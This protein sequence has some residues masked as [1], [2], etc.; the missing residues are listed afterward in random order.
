M[1]HHTKITREESGV[2]R[3]VTIRYKKPHWSNWT[4]LTV[5]S[6]EVENSRIILE[7]MGFVVETAV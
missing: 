1:L 5:K 3:M 4:Y 2:D 6:N 7:L